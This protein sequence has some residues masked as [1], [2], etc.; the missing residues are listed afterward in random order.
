MRTRNQSQT[1]C[2][3]E[4][5]CHCRHAACTHTWR[6]SD[7][8]VSAEPVPPTPRMSIHSM[9]DHPEH[10]TCPIANDSPVCMIGAD[11]ESNVPDCS[12]YL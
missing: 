4:G 3:G 2:T 10:S 12:C 5:R 1:G 11:R 6:V 8:T 9:N 7:R